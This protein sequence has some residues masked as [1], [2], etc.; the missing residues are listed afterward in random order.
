MNAAVCALQ[1]FSRSLSGIVRAIYEASEGRTGPLSGEGTNE[2]I[3]IKSAG[4]A[5]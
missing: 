3:N 2:K 5:R 4:G 1:R